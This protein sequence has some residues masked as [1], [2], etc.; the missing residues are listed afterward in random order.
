[1]A[2][3]LPVVAAGH[4]SREVER[5]MIN[6]TRRLAPRM[7]LPL[8]R[9]AL[10]LDCDECFEIGEG[11]CPA[12]GSETWTPLAR[13]MEI[14]PA[15]SLARLLEGNHLIVVSR[16]RLKLYESL[17]R[18]LTGNRTVQVILDRRFGERRRTPTG[19][20]PDRRKRDR[21]A[22]ASTEDLMRAEHW[23]LIVVDLARVKGGRSHS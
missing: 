21:R 6:S 5:S 11:T 20:T 9:L 23:S 12:C 18:T 19:A 3:L 17:K 2:F 14:A 16:E 7:H 10:C 4:H 22:G 15:R 13:F 8:R 1:M